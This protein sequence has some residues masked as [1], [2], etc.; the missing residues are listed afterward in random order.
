[1]ADNAAGHAALSAHIERIRSLEDFGEKTAP[2][3][4]RAVEGVI[5]GNVARGVDPDGKAWP[6]TEDG[7]TPL[8]NVGESLR[9]R[10]VKSSIVCRLEGRHARHNLGR[11]KGG[12]RRQVLPT[13]SIPAAFD[14]AIR[15]VLEA[16]FLQTMAVG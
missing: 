1:M 2:E 3:I 11:V 8:Q 4:A 12:K 16:R 14:R 15:R 9:V 6:P 10:A 7:H 13:S 5:K